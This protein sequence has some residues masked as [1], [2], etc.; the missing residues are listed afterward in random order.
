MVSATLCGGAVSDCYEGCILVIG[1]TSVEGLKVLSAI[2]L[3]AWMDY[4]SPSLKGSLGSSSSPHIIVW[5][6]W[7]LGMFWGVGVTGSIRAMF[8]DSGGWQGAGEGVGGF[9]GS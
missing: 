4:A 7:C 8:W 6:V 9:V 5:S 2:F 3:G 1:H